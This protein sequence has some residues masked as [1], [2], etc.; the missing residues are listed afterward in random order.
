M[1]STQG[2]TFA[3]DMGYQ[4]NGRA[5]PGVSVFKHR[6]GKIERV[7]DT[8]FA[9]GDDFCMVWHLFDLIPEGRAG[10]KPK[11]SYDS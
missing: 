4:A 8:G 3:E 7:A 5:M 9:P 10:W 2:T 6:A 1:V 11:F